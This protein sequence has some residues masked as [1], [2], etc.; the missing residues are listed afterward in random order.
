[1]VGE[2]DK[3]GGKKEIKEGNWGGP[4]VW[5]MK[6]KTIVRRCIEVGPRCGS[7][8]HHA[9]IEMLESNSRPIQINYCHTVE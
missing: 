8:I 6:A 4:L 3:E 2:R 5:G 9:V 7:S 1:M